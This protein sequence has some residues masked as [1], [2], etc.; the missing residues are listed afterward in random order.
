MRA[1]KPFVLCVHFREPHTP[2]VPVP[3][4]DLPHV[5]DRFWQATLERA[6]REPLDAKIEPLNAPLPYHKYKLTYR[7]LDGVPIRAYLAK[8]TGDEKTESPR[9]PKLGLKLTEVLE[10]FGGYFRS[11]FR[12]AVGDRGLCCS[13][14]VLC[15]V[16]DM[17]SLGRR[18]HHGANVRHHHF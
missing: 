5:F 11:S 4:E 1:G 3:E 15:L 14:A 6:A 13:A 9:D 16:Y 17:G 8:A 12:L 18:P 7:S 10:R 2:Y